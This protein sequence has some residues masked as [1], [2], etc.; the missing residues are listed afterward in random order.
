VQQRRQLPLSLSLGLGLRVR[1]NKL[2]GTQE[3]NV[4]R[5]ALGEVEALVVEEQGC[6]GLV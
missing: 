2:I 3:H 4:V 1:E 6:V 5:D